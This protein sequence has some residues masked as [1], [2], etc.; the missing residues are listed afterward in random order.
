MKKLLATLA[1]SLFAITAAQAA[2]VADLDKDADGMVS[3]EE[4]KAMMPDLSDEKFKAADADG[5]G[6]LSAEELAALKG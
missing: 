1:V 5:D 4:A 2:E 3:M 6:K